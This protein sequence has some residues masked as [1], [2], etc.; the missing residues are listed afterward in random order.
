MEKVT[1]L[2]SV[3]QQRVDALIQRL[4]EIAPGHLVLIALLAC[5]VAFLLL[6]SQLR[7]GWARRRMDD[8]EIRRRLILEIG[9]RLQEGAEGVKMQDALETIGAR[10][11]DP[12]K[13]QE[14]WTGI[15]EDIENS[16]LFSVVHH[17][18]QYP[19][20]MDHAVLTEEGRDPE[21]WK[22]WAG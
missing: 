10:I 18:S 1:A 16:G 20:Y 9:R 17:S 13:R 22:Y 2:W 19:T 4:Y 21:N 12:S 7:A 15:W 8:Y 14:I 5:L 11:K 6:I 3:L